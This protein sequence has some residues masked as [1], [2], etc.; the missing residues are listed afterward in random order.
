MDKNRWEFKQG[1]Q[2]PFKWKKSGFLCINKNLG[3][4]IHK[5]KSSALQL[6]WTDA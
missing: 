1:N 4:M 2:Q 5:L 3:R 6:Y